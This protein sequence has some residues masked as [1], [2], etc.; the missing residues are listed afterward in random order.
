[1]NLRTFITLPSEFTD[2]L[3]SA[4]EGS[5]VGDVRSWRRRIG[6]LVEK[7]AP[8]LAQS[9]NPWLNQDD[10]EDAQ[11]FALFGSLLTPAHSIT[12]LDD[13]GRNLGLSVLGLGGMHA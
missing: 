10:S 7:K 5:K 4:T 11:V 9:F 13:G 8:G 3:I 2:R 6:S 12:Q 1:M